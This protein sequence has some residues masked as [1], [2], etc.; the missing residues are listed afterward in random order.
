MCDGAV[1]V[2]FLTVA[3]GRNNARTLAHRSTTGYHRRDPA[4]DVHAEP[5]VGNRPR[6]PVTLAGVCLTL[7]AVGVVAASLGP[8]R[9]RAAFDP[10]VALRNS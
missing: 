5:G 2:S 1:V 9:R 7:S 10:V 4:R 8:A 6:D 3:A